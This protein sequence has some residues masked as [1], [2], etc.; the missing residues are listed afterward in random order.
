MTALQDHTPAALRGM[1]D[2]ALRAF[3]RRARVQ[4]ARIRRNRPPP[5]SGLLRTAIL[6]EG[7]AELAARERAGRREKP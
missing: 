1:T 4:A 3:A 2:A 7:L 5:A 6:L